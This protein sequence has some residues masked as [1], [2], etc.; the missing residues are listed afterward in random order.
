MNLQPHQSAVSGLKLHRAYVYLPESQWASIEVLRA[1]TG[2]SVSQLISS[3]VIK[4]TAAK[5]QHATAI[6]H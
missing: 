2:L 4:A 3:L 1:S 5:E 6:S